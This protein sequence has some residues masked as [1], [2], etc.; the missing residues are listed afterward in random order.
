[1]E[2]DERID[3]GEVKKIIE[4]FQKKVNNNIGIT[5]PKLIKNPKKHRLNDFIK[6]HPNY[7]IFFENELLKSVLL[8]AE[9]NIIEMDK[10][11]GYSYITDVSFE[12][13]PKCSNTILTAIL[14]GFEGMLKYNKTEIKSN[15]KI[16]LIAEGI[17]MLIR[18]I[19]RLEEQYK[20]GKK[21]EF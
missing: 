14:S 15:R 10:I 4:D 5:E 13:F 1:M 19:D 2:K 6:I 9:N 12:D 8:D 21:D 20:E 17:V 18:L 11:E 7:M 16:Q 3:Y